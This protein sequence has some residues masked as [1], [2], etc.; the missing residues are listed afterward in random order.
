MLLKGGKE[1]LRS[2]LVKVFI[3]MFFLFSWQ[4]FFRAAYLLN[5]AAEARINEID[6]SSV[7][8]GF[9][10]EDSQYMDVVLENMY[11]DFELKSMEDQ[12]A[13]LK[14][15]KSRKE[16]ITA[17][18]GFVASTIQALKALPDKI[19][20]GIH[21]MME[22]AADMFGPQHL[23]RVFIM[24]MAK[25]V[26]KM[27]ILLR[28]GFTLIFYVTVPFLFVCSYLPV[29]GDNND[30]A[31]LNSFSK[32]TIN[33]CLN[34]A[35]WPTIFALLDKVLVIM[36]YTL[37]FS[38]AFDSIT[39]YTAFFAFYLVA[40]MTIPT[41]IQKANPYGVM[42]GML[43]TT[44][45][46]GTLAVGGASIAAKGASGGASAAASMM[47]SSV[48]SPSMAVSGNAEAAGESA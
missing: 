12:A 42:H 34:M 25:F 18:P 43:S 32:K 2:I 45:L 38:G 40:Y 13:E 48:R 35:M 14:E 31:G 16:E 37:R 15:L 22:K 21:D 46:M 10:A 27:I 44:Q 8:P 30:M 6:I 4:A 41:S 19:D 23:I 3:I 39:T 17:T 1:D 47:S 26:K 24:F 11:T 7:L 33:W 29:L 28:M 5:D 20:T 36:Y 9:L